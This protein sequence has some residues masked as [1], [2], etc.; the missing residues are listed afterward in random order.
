MSGV[1]IAL[2]DI[3]A[4]RAGMPLYQLNGY[5][6]AQEKPGLGI[7]VDEKLAAKFP[8][9]AGPPNFDYSWGTNTATEWHCHQA[10]TN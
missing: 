9:P 7:E 2:W 6:L 5:M 8:I 10:L 1:D 4:K 3:K